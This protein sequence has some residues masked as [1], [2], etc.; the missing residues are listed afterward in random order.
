MLEISATEEWRTAH[1]GASIGVLELSGLENKGSS[2][3]LNER[4]RELES[5]VRQKYE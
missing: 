1:P 2:A 5:V 3:R 4:K